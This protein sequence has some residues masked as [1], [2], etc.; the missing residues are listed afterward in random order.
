MFPLGV[1]EIYYWDICGVAGW[2]GNGAGE[3]RKGELTR[4][5]ACGLIY[6]FD[7]DCYVR[8]TGPGDPDHVL[9]EHLSG[10]AADEDEGAV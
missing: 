10:R 5:L 8:I 7:A 3:G 4:A 2:I 9:A 1:L 6:G